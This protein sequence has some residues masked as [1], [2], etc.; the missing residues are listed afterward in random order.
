M[1]V[2]QINLNLVIDGWNIIR[3]LLTRINNKN[4]DICNA[5]EDNI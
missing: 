4:T 5:L 3:Q 1:K 2:K